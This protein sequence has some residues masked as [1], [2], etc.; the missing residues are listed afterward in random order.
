MMTTG[1]GGMVIAKSPEIIERIRDLKTYDEKAANR[2]RY[3]YKMTEIQAAI[4][5]VQLAQLDDFVA[6]RRQIAQ[7]YLRSFKSLAVRLPVDPDQH[8]FYRFSV[9]LDNDCEV[10][11]Q[12]LRRQG[13]GC[14]RPVFFPIHRHHKMDGYLI[15]DNAW[16]TTLSIPIY[17]SLQPA[18]VEHVIERF[19]TNL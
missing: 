3:N 1:E 4:G 13:V 18:A 11:L 2:V 8:I 5:E 19:I 9:G 10:I 17:P 6:R 14:A 7:R 15:T 16:K 12:K